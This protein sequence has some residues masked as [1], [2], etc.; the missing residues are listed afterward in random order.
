M[1]PDSAT[2]LQRSD[3]AVTA[4]FYALLMLVLAWN[5]IRQARALRR[6]EAIVAAHPAI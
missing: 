3:L 1:P 4:G 2:D 6:V 5:A